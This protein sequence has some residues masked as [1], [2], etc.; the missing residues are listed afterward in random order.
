MSQYFLK[1]SSSVM[2]ERVKLMILL[3][4]FVIKNYILQSLILEEKLSAMAEVGVLRY[5]II[6]KI[7]PLIL[8][9][10]V[11]ILYL[12]G[13]R[14]SATSSISTSFICM[15]NYTSTLDIM[16]KHCLHLLRV[17]RSWGF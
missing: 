3:I 5:E 7:L 11:H 13:G 16:K 8:Q 1:E 12:C 10:F 17:F 2:N 14:T 9:P 15:V 4:G 6:L